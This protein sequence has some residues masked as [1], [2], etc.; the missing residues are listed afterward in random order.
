MIFGGIAV[1][2]WAPA[3]TCPACVCERATQVEAATCLIERCER[4]VEETVFV[5]SLQCRPNESVCKRGDVAMCCDL[6]PEEGDR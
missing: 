2:R 6:G 1:A 5:E 4:V 3:P